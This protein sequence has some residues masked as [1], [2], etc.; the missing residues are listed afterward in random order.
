MYAADIV[1]RSRS[2]LRIAAVAAH[3]SITGT[4]VSKEN[5]RGTLNIHEN[6][7]ETLRTSLNCLYS[8]KSVLRFGKR[9]SPLAEKRFQNQRVD[10]II[11]HDENMRIMLC[12]WR[13]MNRLWWVPTIIRRIF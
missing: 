10:R 12:F 9:V 1:P 8:Q 7:I 4:T 5:V 6:D 3:P 11:F 13:N 2:I